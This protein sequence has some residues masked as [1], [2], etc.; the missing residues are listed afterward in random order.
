MSR[1]SEL[2][3][4]LPVSL[5]DAAIALSRLNH[6]VGGR[7]ELRGVDLECLDLI[8]RHGPIGPGQL[9]DTTAL[10]PATITGIVDRLEE[11]G[12]VRRERAAEDRRKVVLVAL[13][14][15]GVELLQLYSGMAAALNDIC[16]D[17][18]DEEL[19]VVVD[20]LARTAA[21][22]RAA[23]SAVGRDEP[24]EQEAGAGEVEHAPET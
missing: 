4:A 17:Y 16:S 24:T 9:A 7:V 10:H 14:D 21:A 8:A 20:F 5:R 22:G 12:W 19:A 11:G 18:S 1:R 2:R 23:V 15:R 3:G 13:P 6:A